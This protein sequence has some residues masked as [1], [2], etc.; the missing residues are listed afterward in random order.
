[1]TERPITYSA[2][3]VIA[4]RE[5]RKTQ[6]RRVDKYMAMYPPKEAP[7]L[8][9]VALRKNPDTLLVATWYSTNDKF[10]ASYCPY[11]KPGDRLWTKEA[12][13]TLAIYNN[14]PPR[15]VPRSAPIWYEADGPAPAPFAGGRYRHAR[16]M[17]RW[18]SRGLDEI[19]AVRV[20][21]IQNINEADAIAEGVDPSGPCRYL[22]EQ[23][24]N[25]SIY[26]GRYAR[27]W[28]SIHG[29]GAWGINPRVWV[30]EFTRIKP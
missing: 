19:T 11:G 7:E 25:G 30:L 22:A 10:T 20:E 26:C 1:M 28:E 3:M 4:C 18:M 23:L 15:D 21:Q 2:P 5:G 29:P 16:F 9:L 13:R 24:V 14:M 8:S 17:M 27:L 12:W 6:T